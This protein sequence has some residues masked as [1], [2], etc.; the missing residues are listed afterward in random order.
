MA[1]QEIIKHTKKVYKTL[2]S[3]EHSVW[4]KIKELLIEIL[5]IVFAVTLSIWLH[6]RSEHSHQQKEVKEFLWGLKEDLTNDI[7]EMEEDKKSYLK[8]ASA[9]TYI[10]H[11]K[12][13][14]VLNKDSVQKYQKWV[15]N[16]TGLVPNN[17]RFEGFK[18]SGK[19]GTIENTVLQ[20]DIMDLYQEN[21]PTLLNTTGIYTLN[22]QKF[23]DYLNKYIKRETD[24]TTNISSVLA[25]DEA[26]NM[27]KSLNNVDEILSR[28]NICINKMNKIITAI[29]K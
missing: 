10:T 22:K 24:S 25:A 21:I 9:F 18:S 11:I 19:I 26:Q 3:K 28:Y 16:S 13:N 23:H 2:S 1:E 5:I 20:N 14:E 4:Y 8:S 15:L 17:G 12:L 27:S 6:D 7:K 29:D